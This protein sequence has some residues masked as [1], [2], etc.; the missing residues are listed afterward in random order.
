MLHTYTLHSV[1]LV[2]SITC[3]YVLS[4]IHT[5]LHM[6]SGWSTCLQ[7]ADLDQCFWPC[8][9]FE[10][11]V[12]CQGVVRV[13]CHILQDKEHLVLQRSFW[14]ELDDTGKGAL[15]VT[16]SLGRILKPQPT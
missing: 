13:I 7:C 1:T 4:C 9:L 8:P 10:A 6:L 15:L 3:D 2:Q 11:R 16:G 5:C 14:R 12:C